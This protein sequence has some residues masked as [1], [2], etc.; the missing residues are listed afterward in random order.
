MLESGQFLINARSIGSIA[1]EV[2]SEDQPARVMGVSSNGLFIQSTSKWLVFVSFD[3]FRSP[4]TITLQETIP[5]T[6]HIQAGDQV[7]FTSRRLVIP[8]AGII[9][10]CGDRRVWKPAPRP[11]SVLSRPD[12]RKRLEQFAR[13]VLLHKGDAGF[14]SLLPGLLD[15]SAD[16]PTIPGSLLPVYRKILLLRKYFQE[17]KLSLAGELLCT[18]LGFGQGLTPC[19]DDFLIGLLLT[20]NRWRSVILPDVDLRSL[21]DPLINSAYHKTTTLSANLIECAALG[22]ADERLINF[23]DCL[24][25]GCPG[26]DEI[27][28][29]LLDWG[30]SSGSNAFAGMA[31][32]LSAQRDP[33]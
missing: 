10:A 6:M 27:L 23:V 7:Y 2:L 26:S 19:G 20:L 15:L 25:I 17:E 4:L 3:H 16:R 28:T 24:L 22:Q 30:T 8:E 29:N 32:A 11:D 5:P 21:N 33:A 14:S 18:L 13:Q 9:I 12:L 31:V 1:F